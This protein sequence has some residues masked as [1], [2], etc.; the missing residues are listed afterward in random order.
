MVALFKRWLHSGPIMATSKA[1]KGAKRPEIEIIDYNGSGRWS[2]SSVQE[3]Y[4]AYA[5]MYKVPAP[6][7]LIPLQAEKGTRQWIY[8]VMFKVI[9]GI[10]TGDKACIAI[11]VDMLEEDARFSFGKIIKASNARALRRAPLDSDQMERIR[12]RV[13]HMLADGKV[14]HEF[15]E[16]AKLLRKVGL[17]EWWPFIEKNAPQANPYVL[18]YIKYLENHVV[19]EQKSV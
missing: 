15:R 7:D 12:K 3:R 5:R 2:L 4:A 18:R 10:A 6:L 9:E 13:A 14:P 1:K 19:P 16:Y 8:P 11:G 17:G